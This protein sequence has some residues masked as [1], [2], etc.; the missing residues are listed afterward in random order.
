MVMLIKKKIK[1]SSGPAFIEELSESSHSSCMLVEVD[2]S[3]FQVLEG[4]RR[5]E[6]GHC[7]SLSHSTSYGSVT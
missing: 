6:I 4:K 2:F 7:P 5:Q 1:H 3:T